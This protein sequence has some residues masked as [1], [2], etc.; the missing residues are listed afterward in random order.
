MM[1]RLILLRVVDLAEERVIEEIAKG[2]ISGTLSAINSLKAIQH[3]ENT[4][5][6]LKIIP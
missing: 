1:E 5:S 2:H 4:R 6:L 3:L